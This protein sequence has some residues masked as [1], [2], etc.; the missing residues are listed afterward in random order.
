MHIPGI[1][2]L[3]STIPKLLE[4]KRPFYHP[5]IKYEID[6]IKGQKPLELQFLELLL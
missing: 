3:D 5:R 2:E 1:F 4:S 6:I